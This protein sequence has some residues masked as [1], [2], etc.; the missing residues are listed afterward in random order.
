MLAKVLLLFICSKINYQPTG[1]VIQFSGLNF[2]RLFCL[3]NLG[4][5]RKSLFYVQK[6]VLRS[7]RI[8]TC[9]Q[10]FSRSLERLIRRNESHWIT[11]IKF[12]FKNDM[13]VSDVYEYTLVGTTKED[14]LR[15]YFQ[16]YT[17]FIQ[18]RK[19]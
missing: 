15:L 1:L 14:L 8:A 13:V 7:L 4:F 11:C 10:T 6:H 18:L 3:C 19:D 17:H 12:C 5:H 2:N 9:R 16:I